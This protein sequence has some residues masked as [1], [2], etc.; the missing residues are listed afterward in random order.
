MPQTISTRGIKPQKQLFHNE[1]LN[2]YPTNL[3]FEKIVFWPNNSRTELAFDILE[4]QKGKKLSALSLPEITEFLVQ[5]PELELVDLA[6]SI[7]RNG[8]RVPLIVLDD[9]TLLDGN[10]RYFACSYLFHNAKNKR[11]PI[12]EV[13]NEILVWVIKSGD[14]DERMRFKILAEAN[15]V[16]DFKV[17]WSAD[18]KAIVIHDYFKKCLSRMTED[19]VYQEI[20]NV[21]GEGKSQVDAYVE[22]INLSNEFIKS[23]PAEKRNDFREHVQGKFLYFWEFRNKAI[24]SRAALDAETELP[25]VK[26]LFFKMIETDRFKNFKQVEPMIR[27]VRDDYSWGLLTSTQGSAIDQ[28]E[29]IYKEQ[30]AVRSSEDKIR[31]FLRWL[32]QAD[33]QLFTRGAKRLLGDL[34]DLALRVLN[35]EK[36]NA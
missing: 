18:V 10:R 5:R 3:V 1:R 22:S 16:E 19:Q 25:K 26:K 15:Y 6:D 2:V 34:A 17:Q 8:V 14:V 21:F 12:P 35:R 29:V 4:A 24:R 9:G 13:L 36:P 11:E 32:Q 33:V 31:N 20:K 27:A 28:I 7:L 30:K 23:A